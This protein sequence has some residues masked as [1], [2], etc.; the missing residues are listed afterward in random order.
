M[1]PGTTPAPPSSGALPSPDPLPGLQEEFPA[2]R[3]WREHTCDRIRYIA[4]SLQPGLNPHTVVTDDP[5]ELRA[6]L[7]PS[8]LAANPGTHAAGQQ[9]PGTPACP[10]TA[11][12]P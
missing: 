5:G 12:A 2:F 4:R 1:T 11:P 6:A 9:G 7:E 8:R 3:I 10:L